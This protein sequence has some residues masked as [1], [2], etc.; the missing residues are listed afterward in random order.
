MSSSRGSSRPRDRTHVLYVSC[1]GSWVLY[2]LCHL[3]SP[4]ETMKKVKVLA[5][6]LRILEII[7]IPVS[8]GSSW[9][10]DQIRISCIAGRFFTVWTTRE[11]LVRLDHSLW[12]ITCLL[13]AM[14]TLWSAVA[15]LHLS[16]QRTKWTRILEWGKWEE[17][18]QIGRNLHYWIFLK[19][20]IFLEV[21]LGAQEVAK[22][23]Q[24]G[25]R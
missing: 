2:H 6:Q 21:N 5:A 16:Y 4:D 3:G 11:V 10:R 1:T 18:M 14:L 17:Q 24:R 15:F 22:I 7:A 12:Q 9:P 19:H 20:F 25:P 23:L 13:G 8:R